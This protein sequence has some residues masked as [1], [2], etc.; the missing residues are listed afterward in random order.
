MWNILFMNNKPKE[1][2]W[3]KPSMADTLSRT[4]PTR[5]AVL[6]TTR[7]RY[8]CLC[9]TVTYLSISYSHSAVPSHSHLFQLSANKQNFSIKIIQFSYERPFNILN[10]HISVYLRNCSVQFQIN[11]IWNIIFSV[12]SSL[13]YWRWRANVYVHE[14]MYMYHAGS[15]I[16]K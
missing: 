14:Y 12:L 3:S 6:V 8:W 2:E 13:I 7:V 15:R 16:K 9:H 10:L 1:N 4:Y 11:S 5:Y